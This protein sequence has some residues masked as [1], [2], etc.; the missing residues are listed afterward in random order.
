MFSYLTFLPNWIQAIFPA[1]PNIEVEY[2]E[3][4]A[5]GPAPDCR[6]DILGRIPI[7]RPSS[8][9]TTL[10]STKGSKC[11]SEWD[12]ESSYIP[13]KG[14]KSSILA[15]LPLEIRQYI[16]RGV[17]GQRSC[18]LKLERRRLKGW[19]CFSQD[20]S[21]CDSNSRLSCGRLGKLHRISLLLTCRQM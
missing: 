16:W 18:H 5:P 20:P 3:L 11:N 21:I 17:L 14:N 15:V 10:S 12:S 1:Q 4:D 19:V 13:L 2:G 8:P 9:S 6:I 7:T